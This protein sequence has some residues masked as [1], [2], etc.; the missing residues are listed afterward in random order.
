[1]IPKIGSKVLVTT[2]GNRTGTIGIQTVYTPGGQS[3]T[4]AKQ[5]ECRI[6]V[7]HLDHAPGR[8]RLGMFDPLSGRYE[9]LGEHGPGERDV[10]RAIRDLA[11]SITRAG[12]RL[13]WCERST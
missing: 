12:H 11:A 3:M 4:R 10:D 8:V 9:P 7:T 6:V 2:A 1:M 5:L 13:T